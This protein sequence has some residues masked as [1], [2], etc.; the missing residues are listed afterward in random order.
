MPW[1]HEG[2]H[3][4]WIDQD[5]SQFK[6]LREEAQEKYFELISTKRLLDW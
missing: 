5:R 2:H 4:H 3:G 1:I 6:T